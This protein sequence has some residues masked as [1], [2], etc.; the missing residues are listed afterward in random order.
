MIVPLPPSI[1]EAI[2]VLESESINSPSL[3]QVSLPSIHSGIVVILSHNKE[4]GCFPLPGAENKGGTTLRDS[5]F[6]PSIVLHSEVFFRN[7][8]CSTKAPHPASNPKNIVKIFF[9]LRRRSSTELA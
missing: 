1:Y 9:R 3:F 8:S 7:F 6:L 4:V 2:S 5:N